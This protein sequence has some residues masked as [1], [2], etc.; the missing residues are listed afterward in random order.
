MARERGRIS[1]AA[2]SSRLPGWRGSPARRWRRSFLG[3]CF[4]RSDELELGT[5]VL[6]LGAQE[7][8]CT[9]PLLV[10]LSAFTARM[11]LGYVGGFL[12]DL[13]GLNGPSA[14][15][16]RQLF[17][18]SRT[19]DWQSLWLG[20]GAAVLFYIAV[21]SMTQRAVDAIW[22]T[23]S[24]LWDGWW[25]R[26][27]W[28]CVQIV[29][30]AGALTTGSVLNGGR[31]G[32]TA[33]NLVYALTLGLSAGLFHWWGH[34]LLLRGRVGWRDLAPGSGA[35]SVGVV[36]LVVGSPF[37]MPSQISDNV[38]DYGLIGA[39]FILSLWAVTYSGIVVYGTLIGRMI[40][41]P[42]LA[43]TSAES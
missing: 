37:V 30:Y 26:I 17:L 39:A 23:T 28:S 10:A 43:D 15:S 32:A 42:R 7:V 12:D 8:L 3:R 21:A 38:E 20:L 11:H 34:H 13:M 41:E 9:A 29:M 36:V 35:I 18:S 40:R 4:K 1:A 14:S 16:V 25:R 22:G 19:P 6:A 5:A 2:G 31:L 27:T 24:T 33:T